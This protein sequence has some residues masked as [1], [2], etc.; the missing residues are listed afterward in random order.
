MTRS[1]GQR[2]FHFK[3]VIP[4]DPAIKP[5]KSW[6]VPNRTFYT[7][8]R[9]WL[10]EGGY[11]DS[12][13]NIYGVAAR[14]ALGLLDKPY[15]EIDPRDDLDRVRQY[16]VDRYESE[17]TRASYCKG[18][19]KLDEYLHYRCKWTKPARPINWP[20]YLASLPEW[21]A[22]DVRSYVAH[23]QRAWVPA[24]RHRATLETLSHLT[25]CLR[26]M[27]ERAEL[28]DARDLRPNLWFDYL[29]ERLEA[30][31]KPRS[32][33]RELC[34]FQGLLRFLA[35]AGRPVCE[36]TLLVRPLSTDSALP[37]DVP[38]RQ[39]R[40]LLD[41]IEAEAASDDPVVRRVGLMDR[42]WFLLMT[43][44]GLRTCEV[45][46]LLR[47]DIELETRRLWLENAKGLKDR[48]VCLSA[49]ATQA[50]RTYL[51]VRGPAPGDQVF[52]YRHRPLGSTYCNHRLRTYGER[53]G[54]MVT[55]HRLRHSC[56][57]LLL[58]AGAPIVIVQAIL[59]HKHIDTTLEYA[60]VYDGTLAADYYRA[61]SEIEGRMELAETPDDAP[62]GGQM[63]ALVDSLWN[64]TLNDGQRE[65]VRALRTAILALAE[66]EVAVGTVC[67]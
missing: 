10:Q 31:I 16:M 45:R 17:S 51:E 56:A 25:R 21:L 8:F 26:W 14:L 54:V 61:M 38:I 63:L 42:A 37:R 33:N 55:A 12:S 66:Q 32:L 3:N 15:W 47:S 4:K 60:R 39:L 67:D 6:F 2:R 40:R 24:R 11:S 62:N 49:S 50:L 13:L 23:R 30:G 1:T 59:G 65:T 20:Y 35:E 43:H 27:S 57:T 28:R 53:C 44:C 64:G 22:D 9:R 46:S 29:D 18:L 34:G 41:E 58:N 5:L 19:A 52:I 36:R 7:D 48:V